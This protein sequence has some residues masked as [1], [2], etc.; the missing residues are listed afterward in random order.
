[1]AKPKYSQDK[2]FKMPKSQTLWVPQEGQWFLGVMALEDAFDYLSNRT[3]REPSIDVPTFQHPH[4]IDTLLVWPKLR[5]IAIPAIQRPFVWK[6]SKVRNL[7]D[8]LYHG[9]Q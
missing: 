8:S 2:T 1:V 5:E 6:A 7:L 4:P 3:R 9:Y